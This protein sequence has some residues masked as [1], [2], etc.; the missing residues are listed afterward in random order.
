MRVA[1]YMSPCDATVL[2]FGAC[3][4][5]S[6]IGKALAG[7]VVEICDASFCRELIGYLGFDSAR[8]TTAAATTA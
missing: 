6:A 8:A 3:A 2:E 4:A 5:A 7:L 1:R